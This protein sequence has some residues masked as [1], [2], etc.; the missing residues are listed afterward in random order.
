MLDKAKVIENAREKYAKH[1]AF[2]RRSANV[3]SKLSGESVAIVE[4]IVEAINNGTEFEVDKQEESNS[5]NEE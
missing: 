3:S 5:E 1:V 2:V 4:A